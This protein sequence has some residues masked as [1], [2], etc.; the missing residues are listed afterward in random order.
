MLL[1]LSVDVVDAL[2]PGLVTSPFCI[3]D[4]VVI[5]PVVNWLGK[6]NDEGVDTVTTGD[7]RYWSVLFCSFCGST[8]MSFVCFESL[9]ISEVVD[10]L[11]G[12]SAMAGDVIFDIAFV[13]TVF[14]GEL[15][16]LGIE[17]AVIIVVGDAINDGKEEAVCNGDIGPGDDV[18]NSLRDT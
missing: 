1:L 3:R 12:E 16:F 17:L 13:N 10:R 9:M 8:K 11:V 6:I 7:C 15:V 18:K 2:V 14:N 4:V 5:T